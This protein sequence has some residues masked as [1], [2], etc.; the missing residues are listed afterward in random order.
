VGIFLDSAL[1]FRAD[2]FTMAF[3][4][5]SQYIL[6]LDNQSFDSTVQSAATVVLVDFW[7]PWCGPCKAIGPVLDELA[8]EAV[9]YDDMT[10]PDSI[11]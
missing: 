7:A 9:D 2:Y 6:N 11:Y 3:I 10:D 8:E 5:A 4:M 1:A